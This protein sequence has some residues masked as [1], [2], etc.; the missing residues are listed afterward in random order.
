MGRRT[1]CGALWQN[2]PG[3]KGMKM[4]ARQLGVGAAIVLALASASFYWLFSPSIHRTALL[5]AKFDGRNYCFSR[6]LEVWR[7]SL[8]TTY[9]RKMVLRERSYML[10]FFPADGRIRLARVASCA[11]VADVPGLQGSAAVAA[12]NRYQVRQAP[13]PALSDPDI[14]L[15]AGTHESGILLMPRDR[16]LFSAKLRR[17]PESYV[18][19]AIGLDDGQRSE[20]EV[21]PRELPEEVGE[22]LELLPVDHGRSPGTSTDR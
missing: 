13:V 5:D 18:F 3:I 14:Q 2:A 10:R 8:S 11:R 6:R 17:A 22:A 16:Y 7:A 20:F 12:I 9:S 1:P 4:K 19:V 15:D 21:D